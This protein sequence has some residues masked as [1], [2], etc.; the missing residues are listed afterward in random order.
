MSFDK[1]S[2]LILGLSFICILLT[3]IAIGA[4]AEDQEID[5]AIPQAIQIGV[6]SGGAKDAQD[7]IRRQLEAIRK[8]DADQAY[9]LT[10]SNLH[11]KFVSPKEYLSHLRLKLRP[12]YNHEKFTFME[13]S[14]TGNGTIQKVQMKD[15]YG[16]LVTVIYRV[17]QQDNGEWRINSFAILDLDAKPI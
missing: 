5:G 17:S 16:D 14:E 11:D 7:V 2:H 13:Q 4:H 12:I 6:L 9:Q 1:I 8:R 15:R 10:S 3:L